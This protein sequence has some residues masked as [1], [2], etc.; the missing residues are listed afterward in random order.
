MWINERLEEC[1]YYHFLRWPLCQYCGVQ[2]H[3]IKKKKRIPSSRNGPSSKVYAEVGTDG[4]R[5]RSSSGRCQWRLTS[6]SIKEARLE[7][8]LKKLHRDRDLWTGG[9]RIL[10]SDRTRGKESWEWWKERW[11]EEVRLERSGRP[12]AALNSKAKD[13]NSLPLKNWAVFPMP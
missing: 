4:N 11:A 8:V 12:G 6:R 13:D 9:K 5:V 2:S 7:L 1:I 3:K 10:E